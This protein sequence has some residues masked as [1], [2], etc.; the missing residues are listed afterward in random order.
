MRNEVAG[1]LIIHFR[2]QNVPAPKRPAGRPKKNQI[3]RY[4]FNYDKIGIPQRYV[5][6][7]DKIGIPQRYVFNYDKIGIPQR[8]AGFTET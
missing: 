2:L 1:N 8:S 5:F 6:N 7:Y 3:S 4:V